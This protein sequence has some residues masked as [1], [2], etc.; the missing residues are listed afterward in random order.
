MSTPFFYFKSFALPENAGFSHLEIMAVDEFPDTDCGTFCEP[1]MEKEV[2]EDAIRRM[3]SVY[4]RLRPGTV[5]GKLR[6]PTVECLSDHDTPE[7]A[8]E[9]VQN[10]GGIEV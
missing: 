8:L 1:A 9:R 3:Y 7:D 6:E 4:G 2:P 10:L 5:N